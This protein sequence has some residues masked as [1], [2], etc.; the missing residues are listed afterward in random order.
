MPKK[1]HVALDAAFGPFLLP[2]ANLPLSQYFW[3]ILHV[4]RSG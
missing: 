4:G 3:N 1:Y 2:S